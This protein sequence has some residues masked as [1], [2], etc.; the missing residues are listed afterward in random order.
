MMNSQSE[1]IKDSLAKT[2]K[3]GQTSP[4][5]ATPKE[6]AFTLAKISGCRLFQKRVRDTFL[7]TRDIWTHIYSPCANM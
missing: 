1:I 3:A 4:I 6:A 5:L 7:A 2:T